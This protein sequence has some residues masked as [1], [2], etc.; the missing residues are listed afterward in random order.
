LRRQN[1]PLVAQVVG[2]GWFFDF[3]ESVFG[4]VLWSA[5]LVSKECPD[6]DKEGSS[7]QRWRNNCRQIR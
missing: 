5:H 2:A 3:V 1:L 7:H 4:T 6:G